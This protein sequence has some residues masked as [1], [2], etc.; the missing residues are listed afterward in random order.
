[1]NRLLLIVDPQIDFI[2]GSLP[3]PGAAPAMDAL[4]AYVAE[5][6]GYAF[7]IVTCDFHPHDHS[8]FTANGG[9][10]PEH[11]VAHSTGAAIWPALFATLFVTPA[12]V[13]ILC[14]GQDAAT[15]EYSIFKNAVACERIKSIVAEHGIDRID[16]C[17]IAGDVCVLQTLR[18]GVEMFGTDMFR[19]LTQFAPSLDGGVSL[20]EF[21]QNKLPQENV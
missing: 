15:E 14:K 16:V 9:Q 1:M 2:S 18:D 6:D 19:V 5:Q 12:P 3:V 17:G 20:N 13:E 11:C 10:W 4:A 7:K 21:I 8:S